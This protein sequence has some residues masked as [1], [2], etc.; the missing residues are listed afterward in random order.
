[1]RVIARGWESALQEVLLKE[2]PQ[3]LTIRLKPLADIPR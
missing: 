2:G 1:V 3:R